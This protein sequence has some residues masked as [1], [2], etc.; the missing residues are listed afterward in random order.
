MLKLFYINILTIFYSYT[1]LILYSKFFSL[2]FPFTPLT[3][4]WNFV[5][6]FFLHSS[7]FLRGPFYNTSWSLLFIFRLIHVY[8]IFTFF[9]CCILTLSLV[10]LS[11]HFISFGFTLFSGFTTYVNIIPVMFFYISVTDSSFKF[12]TLLYIFLLFKKVFIFLVYIWIFYLK[13]KSRV[14]DSS[15]YSICEVI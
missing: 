8:F 15:S 7:Y 9:S 4:F 10:T 14:S 2:L 13:C 1:W 5:F 12:H 3:L 11:F 6:V